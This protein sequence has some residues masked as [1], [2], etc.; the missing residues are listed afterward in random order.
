MALEGDRSYFFYAP[1]YKLSAQRTWYPF[2]DL[3]LGSPT[4]A[5]EAR[6][7]GFWR[8][9]AKGAVAVNPN[10]QPITISLPGRYRTLAGEEVERLSL[11]PKHAAIVTLR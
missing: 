11:E 1:G 3:D 10:R 5:C 2:Y 6:D 8:R 9:F 7:G 4:A